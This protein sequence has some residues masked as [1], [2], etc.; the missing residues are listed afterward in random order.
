MEFTS[1]AYS[2]PEGD[3]DHTTATVKLRVSG[4]VLHQAQACNITISGGSTQQNTD[5]TYVKGFS[6]PAGNYN[7]PQEFV[8]DNITI[9][10]NTTC[11]NNRT[12]TIQIDN[13]GKC[14]DLIIRSGSN[15]TTI[16]TIE[17]D[18]VRPTITTNLPNLE[19]H[20]GQTVP[21]ITFATNPS[22]A[23]VAW[24]NSNT[25]IGL[26]AS[27]GNGNLPSFT[28]K[29]EGTAPIT[30]TISVTPRVICSGATQ[31][32]SIKV[33]PKL[34]IT[35]EYNG[36]TAPT[37]S[38][39]VTFLYDQ[40]VT[41][42][43]EPTR[44]GYTF[45][46][47]TCQELGITTPAKP[48]VIPLHTD[49]N[50]TIRAD[51]GLDNYTITY[52][53]NGGVEEGGANPTLYDVNTPSFSLKAPRKPGFTFTGW[54]GS[55][56][57]SPNPS[58]TIPVGSTGNKNYTA[59]WTENTY[60]ISYNYNSGNAP[61]SPN[62]ANYKITEVPFDINSTAVANQPTRTGYDFTGW[63]GP[64]ATSATQTVHVTNAVFLPSGDPQNLA[65]TAH[66]VLINYT[67]T[68]HL[69]GG[70]AS[71]PANYTIE[72]AELSLNRP[73]RSGYTFAGW[74]GTGLSGQVMD[75]KIPRGSTGNREYTAHWTPINYT[76]TYRD[77]SANITVPGAPTQ[78][79][80]PQLPLT[81]N[82]EPTKPGWTFTGWTGGAGA[83]GGKVITIPN[84]THANQIYTATWNPITYTIT[85]NLND[86]VNPAIQPE[87]TSYDMA[88]L[89]L[90]G[91]SVTPTRTGYTFNGWTGHG[92]TNHKAPFSITSA[93]NGVPGNLTYTAQWTLDTYNLTY[94]LAGGAVATANPATYT[95]T[96]S[97][98]TLNNPTRTG[99]T[100]AGWTGTD[101]AGTSMSVQI[102][103]GSVGHRSYTATWTADRYT[104]TYNLAEGMV[105]TPNPDE[106]YVTTPTIT[107]N[108]PS[109][110][111]YTFAGWT[112]TGITG[113]STSVQIPLG[114]TGD[115]T[116]TATWT[117][118][119]YTIKYVDDNG[120]TELP[121]GAL[122]AGA[123][124]QFD[125]TELP[126]TFTVTA[127]KAGWTFEGWEQG[128][129]AGETPDV[130][131]PKAAASHAHQTYKAKWTVINYDI[132]Y[133]LDGGT[134]GASANPSTYQVT[135]APITLTPPTKSGYTFAGWTGTN[136]SGPTLNVTIPTGSTG[137]RSYTATWT[138]VTYTIKYVDDNGTTPLTTVSAGAPTQFDDT[139]LPK[140][141]NVTA[142]KPGW[143]FVGWTGGAGAS[144]SPSITISKES[145]SHANQTYR[146]IWTADDYTITFN[147]NGGTNPTIPIN[148]A[149]YKMTTLPLTANVIPTRTGY[150]FAG[151]TGHGQTNQTAPF[152]ITSTTAGVPGNL[153]Y[154][155]GWN[156]ITYHISY[157]L[158]GGTVAGNPATYQVTDN[159]ITLTNPTKPGW[160]FVGWTG[161][162]LA[163]ASQ[164]VTIPQ[165]ST[166]DK[167]Y[168]ATWTANAYTITFD[169]NQGV[170]PTNIPTQW[171]GYN[172]TDLPLNNISVTPTRPG[173]DFTGWTGPGQTNQTAPFSITNATPT[174]PGNLVYVAGWNI[175]TYNI[176]YTLDGGTV[177]PTNPASYQVTTP[178]ITL[179]NPTR[180][181]YTFAG[182]TGTGLTAPSTSV[183]IPTGS[184]G[185][186]DYTATWSENGYTI[187]YNLNNGTA[188]ATP[189]KSTFKITDVPFTINT[190]ASAN[191]PTRTGYD[192]TGWTGHDLT[193]AD[194]TINIQTSTFS[195]PGTPENLTYT[196]NWNPIT[197]AI[198]YT[199]ENGTA[200]A[201]HVT[202]YTIE[203]P[204][205]NLV[206]PTRSG[207]T[208]VGWTGSNGS[209]PQTTVTVPQ[210]TTGELNYTANWSANA[211]TI[212]FDAN[213]GVN[214]TIPSNL[215]GYN[216]TDLPLD[217]N[218]IPTRLGYTFKGWT[219]HGLPGTTDPFRIEN[220]MPG[221]PGN[222]T[223]TA[224]WEL[225]N[226]TLHYHLDGGIH[227]PGN[228]QVYD[229]TQLPV[230][231]ATEP[232]HLDP[233]TV[234]IG[235][236]CREM[237]TVPM[238]LTFTI[239]DQTTGELNFD[240][241]WTKSL[242]SLN[243]NHP[244]NIND[245]LFVCEGPRKLYGDPQGKSWQWILPDGQILNTMN[246]DAKKSGRY[247]CSTNYG[248]KTINETLYVYFLMEN[249]SSSIR[250]I[251]TTGAKLNRAQEFVLDIPREMWPHVTS[252]W[253]VSGG[254]VIRKSSADSLM[255]AWGSMGDK[256]VTVDVTFTYA[257]IRCSKRLS[258]N[259]QIGQ[260]S[261][262]FFVDHRATGGQQ[263]GSSWKD[264]FLNISDALAR[265][266]VGDCI[267]VAQGTYRPVSGR[268]F[269][270][271]QDSI[272]VYGGFEGTEEYLYQ[273]NIA[274]YP[275]V[276]KGNG[277]SVWRIMNSTGS[278]IDGF[279]IEDG[280]AE[281][282]AGV[283]YESASGTVAN[284]IIRDNVATKQGGESI[285][286]RRYM[287]IPH[288]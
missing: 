61:A 288:R 40:S 118:I 50:L 91:V 251:T 22:N 55:N 24:T 76:L 186:R 273:R 219:G 54:T 1:N 146:A 212:T 158:D 138:P 126:K 62:K 134:V 153:V 84:N 110:S 170:N 89:P 17:D 120:T 239:P 255:V 187:T 127:T 96:T 231:V 178:A 242:H 139:Q 240:A 42:A 246:I 148:L 132:T 185:Q 238:T 25:T 114:S 87:W 15:N 257:G 104:I 101:I 4:G 47:W 64:N 37:T 2:E 99:Y 108:N 249:N 286:L 9:K 19:Y 88:K 43:N 177:T 97:A 176:M 166:G 279:V 10:G 141:F 224:T 171:L 228:P 150:T 206:P 32:F 29:N 128:A 198:H 20:Y 137:A 48:L 215:A 202:S 13:P 244:G 282:G 157:D 14:N 268:A 181:G 233:N 35:Y 121:A 79:N 56:G 147:A 234:F 217:V 160:T 236:T 247:I 248:T 75:V 135:S 281:R 241:H 276:V 67:L 116:Y 169:P 243:N 11:Q 161:T 197:Y 74:S 45:K 221:V 190:T 192:F 199:L 28:A 109:R 254:G 145:V 277:A 211:Y 41:I 86:G 95:Y 278:R 70:T 58:V 77:G 38:N 105:T 51:W 196:A 156:I 172:M 220:T 81:I 165:G 195:T 82:N 245:T 283:L 188:P 113:S 16:F 260:R 232:T 216:V 129:G 18:E 235:W 142:T 155:A 85:F 36:G 68:Y 34:K 133:S 229:V 230:D 115:R 204:T 31:T 205:F 285:C 124:K 100:F 102:P 275:T 52:T 265:A 5:Y 78:F 73:T 227:V 59:N 21:A 266:T 83:D 63:T 183:T 191:Q 27:S 122:S 98:I 12:F 149:G 66:W 60:T 184:I 210:G 130:T 201:G 57:T 222:L 106:Y 30:A 80:D 143:T 270:I 225:D 175:I 253:S 284:S 287:V 194:K 93:T 207:W 261:L 226:Y 65:Y 174:V 26:N 140:T 39:P 131:I 264:A 53:L 173:Y 23:T 269:E 112:G 111:G 46:G 218:L 193:V 8:L 252:N 163:S 152:T 164:S 213:N 209:V 94:D 258:T 92:L 123:P 119:T 162:G 237:P 280:R 189:N 3:T 262:G 200:G 7:T 256:S 179:N 272:E 151:W 44:K 136:L 267:W 168:K 107:L 103:Q 167:S 208:F 72:S 6:I 33:Y 180:T 125:D 263:D 274:Q 144:G 71:N 117:P 259:I 250:Y 203:S 154:T 90:S 214:P 271:L 49:K 159:D 223:F 69:D 182:W